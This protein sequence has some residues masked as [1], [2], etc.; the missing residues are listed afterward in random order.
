MLRF[1]VA[2]FIFQAELGSLP[3]LEDGMIV[4]AGGRGFVSLL[5]L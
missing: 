3:L 5:S 4:N 1:F 2:D